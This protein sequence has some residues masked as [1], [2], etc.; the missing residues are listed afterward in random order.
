MSADHRQVCAFH[1]ISIA[2][3]VDM[4]PTTSSFLNETPQSLEVV[5]DGTVASS[6]VEDFEI[7]TRRFETLDLNSN[8]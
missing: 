2:H 1:R 7:E 4:S 3:D 5:R 8:A 6:K